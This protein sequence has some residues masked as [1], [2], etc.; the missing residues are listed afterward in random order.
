MLWFHRLLGSVYDLQEFLPSILMYNKV[1]GTLFSG[2]VVVP[3]HIVAVQITDIEE[4]SSELYQGLI[5]CVGE[6]AGFVRVADFDGNG[7]LVPVI[8]GGG[9][10]VHWDALDD[11][12]LQSDDKVGTDIRRRICIIVPVL[13]GGG[14][15]VT[16]IV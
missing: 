12:T 14:T 11:L 5:A 3:D 9:F 13:L 2:N 16:H 10:F 7:I 15:G 8:A 1:E 4:P 6:L